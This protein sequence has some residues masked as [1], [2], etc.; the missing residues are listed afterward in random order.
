MYPD[1][2]AVTLDGVGF[3]YAELLRDADRLAAWLRSRGVREGDRVGLILPNSLD[4]VVAYYGILRAGGVVVPMNPLLKCREIEH[5]LADSGTKLLL[6]WEGAA[7]AAEPAAASAGVHC[8]LVGPELLYGIEPIEEP[9]QPRGEDTAVILY[10]SGTTGTPKGAELTHTNLSRNAALTATTL[11]LLEPNDVVLGG[12]PLFHVFGQTCALL[13]TVTVGATLTLLPCFDAAKAL[14]VMARDG[15]T[16]FLGVPTM[17]SA[18]LAVPDRG[19][20]SLRVCASGG[21]ALP[22]EMLKR[23]EAEFGCAVLEGYGLS[24]TASAV[25][26]N[27]PDRERKPGSVGTPVVGVEL[28]LADEHGLPTPRGEVGEIQVRG[29]TVMKGYHGKP[30]ETVAAFR[31]GWFTTGDLATV[32]DDGYYF[33]VDRKKDL[34]IRG[35][36]N[37]YPRE[38]EEVLHEHPAVAEAAV[39]GIAHPELGEEIGA[40]VVL[41]P[42]TSAEPDGLRTFVKERLA[43]YKYPRLVWIVDELPKS[44]TGKILRREVVAPT[45]AH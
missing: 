42:G 17:Y 10:T 18:L 28:M 25:A 5:Q 29:A 4:F 9:A 38:V 12:L 34:I 20:L 24:E 30:V 43:A 41:R 39:I 26:F 11:L 35:G 16:V 44:A 37:V 32:D 33:I 36:Y 8:Q 2:V 23:F 14:R 13:A 21:A 45:H 7:E 31:D 27:H 6:A 3:T 19:P 22:M 15:V 40:V 1:H